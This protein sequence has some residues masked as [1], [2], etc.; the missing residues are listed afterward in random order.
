MATDT[1][2]VGHIPDFW[3]FR[4]KDGYDLTHPATPH[5][6]PVYPRLTIQT[7]TCPIIIAPAK[8]AIV[9]V[10]MQNFFL[11]SAMG[12]SKE[13]SG[14]KAEDAILKYTVP[15]ARQASIQIIWLTWGIT[16]SGLTTIPPTVWRI[17]GYSDSEDEFK[18]SVDEHEFFNKEHKAKSGLGEPLGT[19]T[20]E[21]GS[22]VNAGRLLMRDQW[23]TE[24]HK[25]L[26]ETFEKNMN[27]IIPDKRFYK[28]RLSGLWGSSGEFEM[29]LKE[30]Q[31]TT[32]LFCGVNSDQCVIATLQDANSKGY[33]TILLKDCCGT[34]SPDYAQRTVE[35]NCKKS[36]GFV[37]S[38]QYLH[39][40]VLDSAFG[41]D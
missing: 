17:F 34:S 7:T 10:D 3:L 16:D 18:S 33:D 26:A 32:L 40:A 19:V 6:S 8:T 14:R 1:R 37:S 36:W 20:L 4:S 29:F 27:S 28:D 25:P 23:N 39:A 5:S 30:Q 11:S 38:G 15:A 22:K 13:S 35:Y 12:K 31:L 9:I 24:L 41:H 2:V 21:D